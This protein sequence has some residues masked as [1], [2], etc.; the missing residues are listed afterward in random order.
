MIREPLEMSVNAGA[1]AI[2]LHDSYVLSKTEMHYCGCEN[3]WI[4][5]T[6]VGQT[7]LESTCMEAYM[8]FR[9]PGMIRDDSA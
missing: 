8:Q 9:T 5:T 6:A 2:C 7:Q 1:S 4:C 3:R